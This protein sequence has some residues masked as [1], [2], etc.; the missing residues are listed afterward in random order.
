MQRIQKIKYLSERKKLEIAL[1]EALQLVANF[2]KDTQAPKNQSGS[3]DRAAR[4]NILAQPGYAR[5][6]YYHGRNEDGLPNIVLVGVNAEGKDMT[7]IIMERPGG[8]PP[9]CDKTSELLKA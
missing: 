6:R 4:D 7:A 5:L 8:C 2:R 3:F 1:S 9:Y